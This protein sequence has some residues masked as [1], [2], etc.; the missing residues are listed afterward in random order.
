MIEACEVRGEQPAT[1]SS[2]WNCE[3]SPL[4]PE[5]TAHFRH[6]Y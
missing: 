3:A 6:H 4:L 2:P 5:A 1:G